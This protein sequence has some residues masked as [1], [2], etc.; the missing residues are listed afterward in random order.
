MLNVVATENSDDYGKNI[1]GGVLGT[2][3]SNALGQ[4]KI[5]N[6]YIDNIVSQVAVGSVN[7]YLSDGE[8][9]KKLYNY[10]YSLGDVNE[11]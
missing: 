8:R 11:K 4:F 9:L 7:E 6:K 10:S 5:G 3:G 2:V 1:L